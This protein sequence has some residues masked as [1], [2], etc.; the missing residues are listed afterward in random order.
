MSLK[1]LNLREI[2]KRT[3]NLYEATMVIAKR[4]KQINSEICEQIKSHLGDIEVDE[5]S[6]D[7][8]I[9]RVSIISEFDKKAKPTTLAVEEL[10]ND[11]LQFEYIEKNK[12]QLKS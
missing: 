6:G 4:S 1:T 11:K 10:M 5:E 12:H 9:D 3:K 7:D 2:G 8:I